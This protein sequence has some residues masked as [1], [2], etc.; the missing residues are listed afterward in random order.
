V[1]T[2]VK[3]KQIVALNPSLSFDW[4]CCVV[5]CWYFHSILFSGQWC[6]IGINQLRESALYLRISRLLS[7]K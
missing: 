3:L 4:R 7:C 6:G 5:S 2:A 1:L